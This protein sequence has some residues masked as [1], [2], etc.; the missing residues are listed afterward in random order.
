[1]KKE[2]ATKFT[3]GQLK[4]RDAM[5]SFKYV[6]FRNP[7]ER[8]VH[9]ANDGAVRMVDVFNSKK[10][11]KIRIKCSV[12]AVQQGG[13]VSKIGRPAVVIGEKEQTVLD[14]IKIESL[15]GASLT[16]KKMHEL[17]FINIL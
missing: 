9:I 10:F 16:I 7:L 17:V 8:M 12:K 2:V 1:M 11:S 4:L 14:K 13:L 15:S 5:L 3:V 6:Q